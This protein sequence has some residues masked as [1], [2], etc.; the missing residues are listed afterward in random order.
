MQNITCVFFLHFSLYVVNGS[1][2][3]EINN[4]KSVLAAINAQGGV[5]MC[6]KFVPIWLVV[7][8]EFL[9]RVKII[10]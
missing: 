7:I 4:T 8:V 2:L 1:I 9:I 6:G 10:P 5:L 3:M